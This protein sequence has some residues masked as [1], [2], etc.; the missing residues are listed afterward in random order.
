MHP[1]IHNSF[2][3][4]S[5]RHR[6]P[7]VAST[8]NPEARTDRDNRQAKTPNVPLRRIEPRPRCTSTEHLHLCYSWPFRGRRGNNQNRSFCRMSNLRCSCC[9]HVEHGPTTLYP[10]SSHLAC[11]RCLET[12]GCTPVHIASKSDSWEVVPKLYRRAS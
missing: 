5:S 2:G 3:L 7:P 11:R 4:R 6:S 12:L 10:S 8:E 9:L 1:S